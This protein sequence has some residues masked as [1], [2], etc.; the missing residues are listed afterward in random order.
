M[1]E[2]LD[3]VMSLKVGDS[4]CDCRYEHVIIEKIE[5]EYMETLPSL[6]SR[7]LLLLPFALSISLE[8][9]LLNICGKREVVDRLVTSPGGFQ[10]SAL[11]CC[12][13][14]DHSEDDHPR[15]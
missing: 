6:A 9:V 11:N 5:N 1:S 4:V 7:C 2:R 13:P 8:S 12:G 10:C 3:W 15:P 14:V